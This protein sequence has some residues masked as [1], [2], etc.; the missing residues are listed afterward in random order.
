MGEGDKG[1][2]GVVQEGGDA[3]LGLTRIQAAFLRPPEEERELSVVE[4]PLSKVK[5]KRAPLR[6]KEIEERRE[7]NR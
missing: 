5:R 4:K 6:D 7:K 1:D 3:S 2:R